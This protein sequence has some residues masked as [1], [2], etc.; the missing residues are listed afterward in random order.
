MDEHHLLIPAYGLLEVFETDHE[1][2]IETVLTARGGSGRP[3]SMTF[4]GIDDLLVRWL[5]NSVGPANPR[6]RETLVEIGG[7][8]TIFTGPVILSGLSPERVAQIVTH[9]S[10]KE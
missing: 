5:V 7:P 2:N 1:F 6:A 9:L 10:R 3:A 8:H 4:E